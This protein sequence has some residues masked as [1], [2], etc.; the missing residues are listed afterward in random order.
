MKDIIP[1]VE[2]GIELGISAHHLV[3]RGLLAGIHVADHTLIR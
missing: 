1:L 3:N 2:Y